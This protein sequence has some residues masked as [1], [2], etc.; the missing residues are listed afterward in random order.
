MPSELTEPDQIE[1]WRVLRT[2]ARGGMATVYAV[3]D[4]DTGERLAIKLLTQPGA[5]IP[6]LLQEYRA[7]ARIDHPNIVK[8][9]R[10]G[11]TSAGMPYVV[12]EFL[13]GVPA[14]VRVKATGRPGEPGRTADAARIA[15]DVALA[16]GHL[17]ARGI[18]H[19]DLK[20]SNVQVLSDGTTKLL[21]FGTAR[22]LDAY[23]PI[24]QL[25][26][27]VG[28]F[29]YASPEQLTG[30]A[31]DARS[32]LYSLGVLL[33]R[34]LCGRRPF[35]G[36]DPHELARNHLDT[37]P[38]D[39]AVLVPSLPRPLADL[40]LHLLEKLPADR[41]QDARTV[42]DA[43][44]LFASTT[45]ARGLGHAPIL[46]RDT[47]FSQAQRFLGEGRAGGLLLVSGDEGSGRRTF[48]ELVAEEAARRGA[49]VIA[50]AGDEEAF[51]R[52]VWAVR[53]LRGE[54]EPEPL[55]SDPATA[56]PLPHT[57]AEVA[58]LLAN[59]ARV[60]K[61]PTLLAA[62]AFWAVPPATRDSVFRVLEAVAG[63]DAP[64]MLVAAMAPLSRSVRGPAAPN[65]TTVELRPLSG[66]EVATIAA[67]WLNVSGVPPELA[68]RLTRACGGMP[69]PL[70]EIVRALPGAQAN[71]PIVIPVALRD[72]ALSRV[73]A[74]PRAEL[75]LLEAIALADREF[76]DV[77]VAW[78]VD[79]ER[80]AILP[81]LDHLVEAGLV[82]ESSTF[83]RIRD[84]LLGELVRTRTLPARRHLLAR[85][86]AVIA[87]D[88]P[89]SE[90]VAEACRLAGRPKEAAEVAVRW[91]WPLVRAGGW[92]EA[93]PLLERIAQSN[94]E[95]DAAVGVRF[96]TLYGECLAELRLSPNDAAQ[97]IGRASAL[98]QD[99]SDA[100]EVELAASRLAR[101][102]S[103]SR[104]EKALLQTAIAR[105]GDDGER[106][107]R[108]AEGRAHLADLLVRSGDLP[109]AMSEAGR[110]LRAG[111]DDLVRYATTLGYTQ[112]ASGALSDAELTFRT[113]E[114][115]ARG[116]SR[117]AWRAVAG[118]VIVLGTQGRYSEALELGDATERSGRAGAPAQRL[119]ALQLAI[120]EVDVALH[121]HGLARKR[122]DQALDALHGEI[123][124]RLEVRFA[125]LRAR[126]DWESGE[127]DA[128]VTGIEAALKSP[129]VEVARG[130]AAEV[131]GARGIYLSAAGY[132][133][134]GWIDLAAA[135][136]A[137][138]EMG[139]L[140]ALARLAELAT[141]TIEDP[142][143]VEP[144]WSPIDDW[145]AEQDARPAR[146]A[147]AV[148]RLKFV[149]SRGWDDA[150]ERV[151][152][153]VRWDDLLAQLV[154]SDVAALQVH[155]WARLAGAR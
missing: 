36:D 64:V 106:D 10:F 77:R 125:L 56:S 68:R 101:A 31:V 63:L 134:V 72:D 7:L 124:A 103:D 152:V 29:A 82:E 42:A 80:S 109:A 49:R 141:A 59:R 147:R 30:G 14:Q 60:E 44:T 89:P 13:D 71:T 143:L 79:R 148:N 139:A 1:R 55:D 5:S 104:A 51:R 78:L 12:M 136:T 149:R 17:H 38:P 24:T 153:R 98:V 16:L 115:R 87:D 76:D 58:R 15:R 39:P 128:A 4:P 117:T 146:L 112:L 11:A 111:A 53:D 21:D 142:A 86:L 40:V 93:L 137:L 25:G 108:V 61:K 151:E 96:W 45:A 131:R 114:A 28:T 6:R 113:A 73:E 129:G 127:V 144:L 135:A 34:M 57:I 121:R 132:A 95:L 126:L 62:P 116:E 9:F 145:A 22:L 32:D 88:L 110:A 46:G 81:D 69:G 65:S 23:D 94:P 48:V 92:A 70:T 100:V 107:S 84:G 133:D 2:L 35:E 83:W 33:F 50:V 123:P 154:P 3:V 20:S 74:L 8:V 130:G 99:A 105:F 155:P 19:R 26:E 118:L 18:V 119:A 90:A 43:L 37:A 52:L 66:A 54:N 120:S 67:H 27:F 97:A 150:A 140:A 91:A 41:P 122:L 138:V 102:R 47:A 75:R 85:R